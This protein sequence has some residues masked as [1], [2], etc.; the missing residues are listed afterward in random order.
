[1]IREEKRK[2]TRPEPFHLGAG[3]AMTVNLNRRS[4]MSHPSTGSGQR[5]KSNCR[6]FV[7]HEVGE[8]KG[9]GDA[10]K[11]FPLSLYP[12]PTRGEGIRVSC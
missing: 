2:E 1:M 3:L 5:A 4:D 10:Q 11:T 7:E 6:G 12:S 8:D 9:E